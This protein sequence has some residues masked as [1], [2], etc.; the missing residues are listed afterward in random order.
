MNTYTH[1][2]SYVHAHTNKNTCVDGH[3]FD[4]LPLLGVFSCNSKLEKCKADTRSVLNEGWKSCI[5]KK[6]DEVEMWTQAL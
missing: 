1:I 4:A 5:V 3:T 2:R 6:T